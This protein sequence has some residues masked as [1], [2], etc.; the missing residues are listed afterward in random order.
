M[1]EKLTV[2]VPGLN[3]ESSVEA[4]VEEILSVAETL[5]VE[6]RILMIDDGSSDRTRE[7]MEG[8][9]R[10]HPNCSVLANDRNLG[11]GRSVLNAYR[12][13]EKGTWACV[14]PADNEIDFRSIR[15]LLA[16]REDHDLVLG[17]LQNPIIRPFPRR[18]ASAAFTRTVNLVFGFWFR[19]L[20]GLKLYRVEIFQGLE[21]VSGGHA[22]NAELIAKA[23]LRKPDLRIGE[24]P[25]IARG[26]ARGSSKAFSLRGV[27]R[28]VWE[29]VV[30]YRSTARFR[31]DVIRGLTVD[32]STK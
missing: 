23:L 17:Y 12:Q 13:L 7:V 20:N 25:F 31:D 4:T 15:N 1:R 19:Y 3:E 9:A 21:V 16:I 2:I 8:I 6:T 26:R 5:P 30:G 18:L 24:A 10:R 29:V 14:A 32:T 27:L 28:A 22:F 11:V